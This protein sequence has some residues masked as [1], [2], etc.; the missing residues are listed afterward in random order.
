MIGWKKYSAKNTNYQSILKNIFVGAW[1]PFIVP[2]YTISPPNYIWE[3]IS[4][5]HNANK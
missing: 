3:G 2:G 1:I 4:P 5:F